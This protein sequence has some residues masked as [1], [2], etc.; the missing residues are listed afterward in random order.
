MTPEDNGLIGGPPAAA[1]PETP[2]GP[3]SK[4]EAEWAAA[5]PPLEAAAAV[6]A[7]RSPVT[8]IGWAI[9]S[10]LLLAAWFGWQ[11]GW[12]W[13]L[14]GVVGVFVH[15]FGHMMVINAMGF[16]PSRLRIIPFL[17]GAATMA[18]PP[19]AEFKGV[20]IALA[21]PVFGLVAA[22]PFFIAAYETHDNAW[23]GG[24][25]L[26]GLLNLINL[27]P[28][29]PLDGSKA[30]GPALARIHPMVERGALILVGAAAVYWAVKTQNWLFGIFVGI[31]TLG[32]FRTGVFRAAARPLTVVE[33][34]AS[35]ALW[36]SALGLCVGVIAF[37]SGLLR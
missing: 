1:G 3:W 36:L 30:L 9:V 17:G 20:I 11:M 6:G 21:G 15:E 7:P 35:V 23:L 37:S 25:F 26:I 4:A 29:P 33:W 32:A 2:L 24:A 16:G 8:E 10:T 12:I 34:L 27:A 18:R 13:A 22:I 5:N 14:A 28:A 19:D 31:A